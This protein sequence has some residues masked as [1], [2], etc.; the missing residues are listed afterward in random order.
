MS[1]VFYRNPCELFLEQYAARTCLRVNLVII[2][3][4]V[5]R[6]FS[7]EKD[8]DNIFEI[9]IKQQ[10]LRSKK[11]RNLSE[12]EIQNRFM[13]LLYDI[14]AAGKVNKSILIN[15]FG[16]EC[17]GAHRLAMSLYLG[18]DEIPC[19]LKLGKKK[20]KIRS[21]GYDMFWYFLN[22]FLPVEIETILEYEKKIK[23]KCIALL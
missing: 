6:I 2:Y 9:Y 21:R 15:Q 23:K 14:Q 16:I 17:D 18:F 20:Y 1:N 12:D 22:K 7:G 3:L 19:R 11:F 13:N 10:R 4:T 8:I 5:D